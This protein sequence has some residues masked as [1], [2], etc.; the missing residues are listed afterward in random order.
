M[1]KWNVFVNKLCHFYKFSVILTE[2]HHMTM[3]KHL[4]QLVILTEGE[5]S[6]WKILES[7]KSELIVCGNSKSNVAVVSAV[8]PCMG[9]VTLRGISSPCLLHFLVMT[10][11]F[12]KLP[13]CSESLLTTRLFPSPPRDEVTTRKES[14]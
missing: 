10:Q 13:N 8:L 9:T 3:L 4:S 1:D 2:L 5:T 11:L 7:G 6:M 14:L 12:I